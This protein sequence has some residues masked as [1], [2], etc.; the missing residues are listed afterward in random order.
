MLAALGLIATLFLFYGGVCVGNGDPLVGAF[1]TAL[2]AGWMGIFY[3]SATRV[4]RTA[5]RALQDHMH[6]HE[7]GH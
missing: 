1:F 2:G 7:G 3:S 6:H 5:T 4:T